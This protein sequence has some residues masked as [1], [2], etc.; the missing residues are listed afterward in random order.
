MASKV[1]IGE[2]LASLRKEYGL[3]QREFAKRLAFDPSYISKVESLIS[4][5]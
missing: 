1:Q 5:R 4:R 3:T 2:R